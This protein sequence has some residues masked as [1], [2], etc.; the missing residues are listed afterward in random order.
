[1]KSVLLAATAVVL[2]TSAASAQSTTR[3]Y[4]SSG[5]SLGSATTYGNTTNFYDANGRRTTS[6]TR[7]GNTT[8]FYDAKGN[9]IGSSSRWRDGSAASIRRGARLLQILAATNKSL[10]KNEFDQTRKIIDCIGTT[11]PG[12]NVD[13]DYAGTGLARLYEMARR[14][15]T[16]RQTSATIL[17]FSK[18][19]K[20]GRGSV[21]GSRRWPP[22]GRW[23][24][25]SARTWPPPSSRKKDL[26]FQ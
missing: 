2:I 15:M 20:L 4:S 12:G 21:N 13:H 25:C 18:G 8:N 24:E 16:G 17:L 5:K 14:Q 3:F 19:E 23:Q 10:A 26:S 1:M 7:Y 22:K 11:K 9:R 6:A